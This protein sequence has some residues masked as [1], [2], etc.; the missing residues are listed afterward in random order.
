MVIIQLGDR[1]MDRR[2]F[3]KFFALS[4][5]VGQ[6]AVREQVRSF[7]KS[8]ST[9]SLNGVEKLSFN[10]VE[11]EVTQRENKKWFTNGIRGLISKWQTNKDAREL[12][13]LITF[14][15]AEDN[16]RFKNSH[17]PVPCLRGAPGWLVHKKHVE[18]EAR[19]LFNKHTESLQEQDLLE[20]LI[21]E[22]N[23]VVDKDDP[24]DYS[25]QIRGAFERIWNRN[26]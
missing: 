18:A 3:M 21:K 9:L 6:S 24:I 16:V 11:K 4:P 10:G 2:N 5:V 25:Y 12:T 15:K 23:K 22:H 8:F 1:K 20:S 14:Q 26:F 7:D 19:F 13:A 17:V